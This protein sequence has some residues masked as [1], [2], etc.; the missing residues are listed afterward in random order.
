M[1]QKA[2]RKILWEEA[3]KAGL[4]L[5][6]V[7]T[8][9]LFLTQFAGTVQMPALLTMLVTTVLW[10]GKFGGC[11]WLMM[12]FMKQFAQQNPGVQNSTTYRFGMA[13]SILSALVY[14]AASF[15]NTAFI[16]ADMIAENTKLLMEQMAPVMDSNSLN[17][18]EGFMERLPQIT[19]F[20]NLFYCIIYGS[21]LSFILSRN[22]PSKNPFEN[23]NSAKW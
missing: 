3:G 12:Y 21:I 22:I 1:E 19:F 10:A 16:S 18:M 9:Y 4:A 17:Q 5:G 20:S 15:A 23:D 6:A 13:A 7:S 8:A 14:A 2:L 11:I